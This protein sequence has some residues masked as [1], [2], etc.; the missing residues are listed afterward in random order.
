MKYSSIRIFL[1]LVAQYELNLDQ[2]DVKTAFLHDDLE[3]KIYISQLMGFK[4]T[5]KE[6]MIYKLKK[7]L[8]RLKQSPR[9]CINILTAS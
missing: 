1:A 2:I 6:N 8:Y 4:T 5:R 7:A 3:E 9:Q